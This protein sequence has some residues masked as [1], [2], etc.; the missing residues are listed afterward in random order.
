MGGVPLAV[1]W[2]GA[3]LGALNSCF[4]SAAYAWLT[5]DR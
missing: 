1:L 5:S 3:M 2:V 4:C